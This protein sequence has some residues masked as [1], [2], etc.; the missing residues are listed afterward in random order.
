VTDAVAQALQVLQSG[1]ILLY[2]TETIHGLGC[3]IQQRGAI[4]RVYA[5]KSRD[6][7][8]P[9]L[10]LAG[11]LIRV[12]RDFLLCLEERRALEAHWPG[13]FTFLL[14]PRD[15]ALFAHMAGPTGRVGV[16]VSDRPF[17]KQLFANW[18][19]LLLSTSANRAGEPYD[20]RPELLRQF[21]AGQVDLAVIE[22]D[23]EGRPSA[24]LEWLQHRENP[25]WQLHREGPRPFR[26]PVAPT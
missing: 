19:G 22:E 18:D 9:C 4:E 13:P 6:P 25:H 23:G 24:L 26:N 1:G 21:A 10:C 14:R 11:S 15:P 7:A 20:G 8:K 3:D 2:P 5:L 16:R 17:L 12:E